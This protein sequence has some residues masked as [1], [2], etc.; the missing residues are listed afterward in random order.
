MKSRNSAEESC[1]APE[2]GVGEG[3]LP[4]GF[5]QQEIEQASVGGMRANSHKGYGGARGLPQP[6]M[7]KPQKVDLFSFKRREA[8]SI[9][10]LARLSAQHG[11]GRL[12]PTSESRAFALLGRGRLDALLFLPI[13]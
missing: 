10:W 12:W 4:T 6:L 3:I 13:Q 7:L 1:A 9:S 5:A 11:V 8:R 2:N